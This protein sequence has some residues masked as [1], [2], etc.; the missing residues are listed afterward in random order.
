MTNPCFTSDE[1]K[2]R[3][4]QVVLIEGGVEG[5]LRWGIDGERP[6]FPEYLL[7]FTFICVNITGLPVWRREEIHRLE[8]VE[9]EGLL[10]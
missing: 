5:E 3:L 7:D 1:S 8:P 4:I 6:E 9:V 2:H 10:V